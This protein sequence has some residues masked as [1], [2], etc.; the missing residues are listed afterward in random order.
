M[1]NQQMGQMTV[2][3]EGIIFRA[4]NMPRDIGIKI[5][6]GT[7]PGMDDQIAEGLLDNKLDFISST[8]GTLHIAKDKPD[9]IET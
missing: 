6:K 4:Q 5:L 7:W 1:S 9:E 8:D 3:A 2:N